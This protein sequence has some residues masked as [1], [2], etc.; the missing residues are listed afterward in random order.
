MKKYLVILIVILL[1]ATFYPGIKKERVLI[2][3][4]SADWIAKQHID[5]TISEQDL[6]L[7]PMPFGILASTYEG[8]WYVTFWGK[9][10]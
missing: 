5:S 4:N 10:I 6:H 7:I 2:I 3:L 1:L 9:V 8:M